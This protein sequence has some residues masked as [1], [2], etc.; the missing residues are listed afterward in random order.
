[1]GL[2]FSGPKAQP[3]KKGLLHHILG[4]GRVSE[5]G[6]A[7]PIDRKAVGPVK[8]TDLFIGEP[9]SAALRDVFLHGLLPPF[10]VFIT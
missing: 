3:F 8:F 10:P 5:E 6:H 4:V 9:F 7:D 2:V 1:M